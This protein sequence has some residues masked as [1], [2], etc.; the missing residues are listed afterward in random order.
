MGGNFMTPYVLRV[1]LVDGGRIVELS[2]GTGLDGKTPIYGVS[3]FVEVEGRL[4]HTTRSQCLASKR[5][6][7]RLYKSL[8]A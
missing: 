6:A 5:M 3:E 1:E 8:I 4:M 2:E 7:Q